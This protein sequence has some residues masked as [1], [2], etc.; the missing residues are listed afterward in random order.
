MKKITVAFL[1]LLSSA[2][3][4]ACGSNAEKTSTETAESSKEKVVMATVGTTKPFSYDADGDL[5]GYDVEVAKAVFEGSDKYEIEFQKIAWSSIFTGLDAGKFQMAGNNFS[6]SAERAEKYLYSLPTASNP[7]ILAVNKDS[8]ISKIADIAGKKTQVV[9]GTST[10]SMLNSFNEANP[11]KATEINYTD[12][13]ITQMLTS[14]DSGRFDYK[15]FETQS[16]KQ[17]IQ[18]QDLQNIELIEFDTADLGVDANPYVYFIFADGED[19]LQTFV[20]KRI[21]EL[22]ADGTLETLS[23]KFLG[24]SYL[25][26]ES[27]M[28]VK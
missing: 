9:Q 28:E 16:V 13:D 19:E 2:V 11:D 22:Y 26:K 6:Y 24:G 4:V 7:L 20:N 27:D 14:V 23:Q 5:T 1:A 12:E 17:I 21:A 18:D 15:I 25:P 8:K 10:A 3:L